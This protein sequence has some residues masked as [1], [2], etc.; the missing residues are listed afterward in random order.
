MDVNELIISLFSNF[1]LKFVILGVVPRVVP[2]ANG[3]QTYVSCHIDVISLKKKWYRKVEQRTFYPEF[4][5]I[6]IK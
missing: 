5:I 1:L 2:G 6:K 4:K 3:T